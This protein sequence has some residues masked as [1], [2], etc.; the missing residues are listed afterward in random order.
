MLTIQSGVNRV[1]IKMPKYDFKCGQCGVV[2]EIERS[3]GEDTTPI[4]CN[5]NMIRIWNATPTIF[6]GTGWG[7]KP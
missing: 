6:K 4:C 2:N 7:A 1:G 5:Q 3:I